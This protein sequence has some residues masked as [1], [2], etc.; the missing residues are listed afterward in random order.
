MLCP[1]IFNCK[2]HKNCFLVAIFT[3]HYI[4]W[5]T[6][7]WFPNFSSADHWSALVSARAQHTLK[8][9]NA[10]AVTFLFPLTLFLIDSLLVSA[11]L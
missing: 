2:S 1:L 8:L 4:S 9:L 6:I 11:S 5:L 3:F 7:H 10:L